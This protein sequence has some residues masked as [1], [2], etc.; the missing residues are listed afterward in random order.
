MADETVLQ[1]DASRFIFLIGCL[2]GRIDTYSIN[3]SPKHGLVQKMPSTAAVA[4]LH[5][6][7]EMKVHETTA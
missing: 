5:L 3:T 1:N 7:K 6:E 2:H 4:L